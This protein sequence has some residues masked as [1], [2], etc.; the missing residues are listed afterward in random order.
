MFLQ[1]SNCSSLWLFHSVSGSFLELETFEESTISYSLHTLNSRLIQLMS[2]SGLAL[3]ELLEGPFVVL[4][5]LGLH[6]EQADGLL[7]VGEKVSDCETQVRVMKIVDS[8]DDMTWKKY[9]F[10]Q[11][12][13]NSIKIGSRVNFS[14][15]H[16]SVPVN[17]GGLY[18]SKTLSVPSCRMPASESLR[19]EFWAIANILLLL[20]FL[21]LFTED[22]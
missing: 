9:G 11:M 5:P 16:N 12:A 14:L 8:D 2:P 17:G 6:D 22:M 18:S 10:R 1:P 13:S 19:I 3:H 4:T 21:F 20:L 7:D 15:R